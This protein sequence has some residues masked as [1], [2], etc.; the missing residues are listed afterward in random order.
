MKKNLLLIFLLGHLMSFAQT[1]TTPY[2]FPV[3]PGSEAWKKFES[4]SEMANATQIPPDILKDLTTAA[5]VKTCLS[6]P[7]FSDLYFFNSLQTGFDGLRESFN[8]FQELLSRKDAGIELFK[9]Y[10]QMNT[11]GV[12]GLKTD[13]DK[14]M[15][16]F[17]FM[18]IEL[19]LAQEEII[20]TLPAEH[21]KAVL[22]EAAHKY[23]LKKPASAFTHLTRSTS[24]L[25]MGRILEK[26]N[27]L[28]NL[29]SEI[30]NAGV[31]NFLS[32]GSTDKA[33]IF[34]RIWALSKQ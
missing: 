9:V 29:K 11:E 23:E 25:I 20:N 27:K 18:Q 26:E 17:Q 3:K 32:T 31:Q 33:E 13:L 16:T 12:K 28:Q 6:F 34:D 8:G 21:R 19:L 10:Q 14:G 30:P 15:F 5:L 22:R 4:R 24:A 1:R 2:D 7:L